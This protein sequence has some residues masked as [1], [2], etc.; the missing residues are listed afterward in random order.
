MLPYLAQAAN[1][2]VGGLAG[3]A[4]DL[5]DALGGPG[6]AVIS[7]LDSMVSVV[8]ADLVMPLVGFSASQGAINLV[9]VIACATA[10]SVVGSL[11]LYLLGMLLG[12]DRARALLLRIPGL[13]AKTVDRAEAWFAR[14]GAKAVMF[15]RLLPGVRAFV[16]LPAGVERMPL[17]KFVVL[18]A[19]GSLMWNSTLLV[20][21]YLLGS[22]WQ[23]V[24]D[25]LGVLTFVLLGAAVL[26]VGYVVVRRRRAKRVSAGADEVRA[27]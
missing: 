3:W 4:T 19:I 1:E 6:I 11:V 27:S 13:K 17:P 8:P 18:T 20:A 14:H 21:G 9:V 25:V 15:G 22:N 2:P 7:A 24:T 10:G 16:S 5:V 12:R 23:V 26:A